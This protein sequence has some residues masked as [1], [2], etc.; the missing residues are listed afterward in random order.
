MS[1]F[2]SESHFPLNSNFPLDELQTLPTSTEIRQRFRARLSFLLLAVEQ[3]TLV[4]WEWTDYQSH[5]WVNFTQQP[6]FHSLPHSLEKVNRAE[7]MTLIFSASPLPF[8]GTT[9]RVS[10]HG[11]LDYFFKM[12]SQAWNGSSITKCLGCQ[13]KNQNSPGL[14]PLLPPHTL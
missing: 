4:H 13:S 11:R 8:L 6:G 3:Q 10:S 2:L 12:H 7:Q 14:R 5:K 9:N 1:Q